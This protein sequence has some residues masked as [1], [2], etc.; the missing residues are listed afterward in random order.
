MSDGFIRIG[1]IVFSAS[2]VLSAAL[3]AGRISGF[4]REIF[5]ASSFGLSIQADLAILLLTLPDLLVG[6]LLS[7]GLSVALIPALQRASKPDASALFL[8][9][10]IVTFA[11]FGALAVFLAWQP[12][13]WLG[14]LAPGISPNIISNHSKVFALITWAIP[15]SALS[16]IT[17][18]CHHANNQFFIAGLGTLIF[19]TSVIVSLIWTNSNNQFLLVLSI[20]ILVGTILRWVSQ[21]ITLPSYLWKPSQRKLVIDKKFV[22][23]FL[24]AAMAASLTLF[25]P[26]IIRAMASTL[27]DGQIAAFNYTIKLVEL[28]VGVLITT[29]GTVLYPQ[30]SQLYSQGEQAQ[31]NKKTRQGIQKAVILSLTVILP[32]MWFM[33][34]VV[35]IVFVRGELN[36][37]AA[38]HITILTQIALL[39]IPFV[40]IGQ[41]A[42]AILNASDRISTVL[43][44]TAITLFLLPCIA[45]LGLT[46]HSSIWLICSLVVF[47]AIQAFVLTKHAQICWLGEQGWLNKNVMLKVVFMIL[48]MIFFIVLDI[49]FIANNHWI[50]MI[51]M[52]VAFGVL[53]FISSDQNRVSKN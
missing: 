53:L 45:L 28:P 27:G 38:Q 21:L 15:L 44:V 30:L 10:S 35:H 48:A 9:V 12:Q 42:A 17:T 6:V 52:S 13:L 39:G 47:Q 19:N 26:V 4:V 37:E 23:S 14:I 43:R 11:I 33:E 46:Y 8:Q 50:R 36:I 40:A 5:L 22:N 7:G 31:A 29:I 20:G 32:G 34:S 41:L 24:S 25:A 3:L 16:G 2:L 18:A 49:F 1:P 51:V